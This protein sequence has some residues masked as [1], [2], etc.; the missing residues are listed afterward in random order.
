MEHQNKKRTKFWCWLNPEIKP[1]T[2][3]AKVGLRVGEVDSTLS[4]LK[5]NNYFKVVH[6]GCEFNFM[7]K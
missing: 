5:T 2:Q 3:G 4:N 7:D 1:P 6:K